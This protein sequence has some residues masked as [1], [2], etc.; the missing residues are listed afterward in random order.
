M[1]ALNCA[2]FM[3]VCTASIA[4]VSDLDVCVFRKVIR[5]MISIIGY[6][7]LWTTFH[8]WKWTK[9]KMSSFLDF[10]TIVVNLCDVIT[11]FVAFQKFHFQSLIVVIENIIKSRCSCILKQRFA[12][13]ES[14]T[15]CRTSCFPDFCHEFEFFL[16]L[17]WS[18][19]C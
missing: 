6:P 9:F 2:I 17:I 3:T 4:I 7:N 10:S 18:V 15:P 14:R 11:V 19:R 1:N 12:F 16:C 13:F 8:A 5:K